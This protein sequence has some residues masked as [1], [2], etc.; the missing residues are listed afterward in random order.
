MLSYQE[1]AQLDLINSPVFVLEVTKEGDPI[2]VAVNQFALEMSKRPL[3]HF[4]GRNALEVYKGSFGKSAYQRHRQIIKARKALEYELTLPFGDDYRQVCATLRPVLDEE[5]K[6]KLI[7]GS[8][9]DITAER[10][11]AELRAS[12][13]TLN[14]EVEQFVSMAAHDLRTPMRNVSHLADMLREGFADRGDGNLELIDLLEDVANKAM[15]LITDVLAHANATNAKEN[16]QTFHFGDLCQEICDVLDPMSAGQYQFTHGMITA[17]HAALQIALRNIIENA[18]KNQTASQL[19]LDITLSQNAGGMLQVR[20]R[21][22]GNGFSDAALR[23][24]DDGSLR[25]DSGYGL[26]GV[27]RMIVARGGTIGAYNDPTDG[28][29]IVEFTLPGQLILQKAIPEDTEQGQ[30]NFAT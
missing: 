20:L 23:F 17:D 11:A 21:D 26:L 1:I 22:N 14:L 3:W 30:V 13:D 25:V 8:S 4:L 29:G 12:L 2:Y 6:V 15:G 16:I 18:I 24:L 27:R 28:G 19:K 9:Y 5:G 7:Y 10:N